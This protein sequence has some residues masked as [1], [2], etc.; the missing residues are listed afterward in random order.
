M[1]KTLNLTA[2]TEVS[3]SNLGGAHCRINNNTSGT[4]YA[5]AKSGVSAGADDVTAIPSGRG[6]YVVGTHGTIYLMSESGGSVQVEGTDILNRPFDSA[7]G[8]GGEEWE[9]DVALSSTSTNPVQ[10]KVINAALSKKADKSDIP[11]SLPANGGNA[12]TVGGKGED[13]FLQNLGS[14]SSGDIK[15]LS[16]ASK[17]GYAFVN[18]GVT[19]MPYDN[20]YWF[21]S[22]NAASSHRN[23]LACSIGANITYSMSYN[24]STKKWTEWKKLSDGGDADTLD[25]YHAA[26]LR[27]APTAGSSTVGGSTAAAVTL[28]YKPSILLVTARQKTSSSV[29]LHQDHTSGDIN[30]GSADGTASATVTVTLTATG[31]EV[32]APGQSAAFPFDYMVFK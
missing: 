24:N 18:S 11:T 3:A 15:D 28:G 6:D 4:L 21:V 19:S 1:I 9:V 22:I 14:W 7:A 25:G 30:L 23:V 20:S 17:S 10:N 5:S 8:A 16:L 32:S 13:N 31:F 12:A 27:S 2:G 26:D 29:L